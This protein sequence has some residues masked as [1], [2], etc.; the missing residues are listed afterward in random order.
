MAM[1]EWLEKGAPF[2]VAQPI[3]PGGLLPTIVEQAT[4]SAED[5][6]DQTL[7]EDNHRPFKEQVEGSQLALDELQCLVE[8]G[9][10]RICKDL[11]EAENILGEASAS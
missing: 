4:L 9:F 8:S 2:G 10:A 3:A 1:A 6:Y 11:D 7:F 5:L